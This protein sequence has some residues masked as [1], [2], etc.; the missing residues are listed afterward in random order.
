MSW[1]GVRLAW[2]IQ[3][4][5]HLPWDLQA[6]GG[7]KQAWEDGRCHCELGTSLFGEGGAG[8]PPLQTSQ[9]PLPGGECPG[10]VDT[11]PSLGPRDCPHMT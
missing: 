8:T 1:A 7:S 5:G 9:L 10:Q 4:S 11:V 3:G 2:V 6:W